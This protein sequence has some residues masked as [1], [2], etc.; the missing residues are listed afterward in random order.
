MSQ[1]SG[2]GYAVV[3]EVIIS[4]PAGIGETA[5]AIALIN[6][7][8]E[9]SEIRIVNAG[10]GYTSAPI[11]GFS[12][13]PSTGIGTYIYNEVVIGSISEAQARVRNFTRRLDLSALNP[14][15]ELQV[16]INTG[17]FF[18]GEVLVGSISSAR[19]IIES[20]DTDSYGDPYDSNEEIEQEADSI[21]D[22][23]ESNPFGE[24]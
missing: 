24:Y 12:S 21:I 4:P 16:S 10:S 7:D 20:Y 11:V 1:C 22:F 13:L 14:P 15:I 18:A 9:V 17:K 23:S 8:S 19:Y 6:T 5:T 3:P 2:S